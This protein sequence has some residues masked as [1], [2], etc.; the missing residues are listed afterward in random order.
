VNLVKRVVRA[1][2]GWQDTPVRPP[3][4]GTDRA[5][6]R[7]FAAL[8][9]VTALI[10]TAGLIAAAVQWSDPAAVVGTPTPAPAIVEAATPT[11]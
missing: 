11:P 2:M 4:S 5:S 3:A 8:V 9:L 1:M 10:I 6:W 7:Q